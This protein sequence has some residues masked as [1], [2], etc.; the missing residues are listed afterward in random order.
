MIQRIVFCCN[1]SKVGYLTIHESYVPAGKSQRFVTFRIRVRVRFRIT[2]LFCFINVG[3]MAFM[4]KLQADL[5]VN[6]V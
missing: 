5:L 3:E 1:P 4:L 2:E 6:V